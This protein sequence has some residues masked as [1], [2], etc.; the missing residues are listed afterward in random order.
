MKNTNE[1][2]R[3]F[4]IKRLNMTPLQAATLYG[5]YILACVEYCD[6]ALKE[7]NDDEINDLSNNNPSSCNCGAL[8]KEECVCD[9]D[10]DDFEPFESREDYQQHKFEQAL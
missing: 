1:N 6:S 3:D 10:D 8:F 2:A 9:R 7:M 5:E 4:L